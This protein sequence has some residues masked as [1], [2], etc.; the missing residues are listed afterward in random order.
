MVAVTYGSKL[1]NIVGKK[2]K[3]YTAAFS[4]NSELTSYLQLKVK[5]KQTYKLLFLLT[6]WL[7]LLI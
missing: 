7:L 1:S 3:E 5:C 2:R 6:V 4:S